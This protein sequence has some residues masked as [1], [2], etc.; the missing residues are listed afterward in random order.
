V[1]G[2]DALNEIWRQHAFTATNHGD[3]H[4]VMSWHGED[5]VHLAVALF[6]EVEDP[7]DM[8]DLVHQAFSNCIRLTTGHARWIS[9]A[10]MV[11][12][13]KQADGFYVIAVDLVKG[14]CWTREADVIYQD[15]G[16]LL[17][18]HDWQEMEFS[19]IE[20][21]IPDGIKE[22]FV[23][24]DIETPSCDCGNEEN[25]LM[26]MVVNGMVNEVFEQVLLFGKHH[27]TLINLA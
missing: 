17:Y 4:P 21:R 5:G 16:A 10:A 7:S 1:S 2:N 22:G 11:T 15:H 20:G 19:K 9:T 26:A 3:F 8:G 25:H 23:G 12:V 24:R 6:A 14:E 27:M 13:N 18:D